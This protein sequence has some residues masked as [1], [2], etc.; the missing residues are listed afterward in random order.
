M[1]S[2]VQFSNFVDNI[3][4]YFKFWKFWTQKM[5]A[6]A[7]E[8]MTI[9]QLPNVS[10]SKVFAILLDYPIPNVHYPGFTVL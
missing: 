7:K 9:S 6:L 10:Y 8:K 5:K 2:L 3:L 4:D 1:H